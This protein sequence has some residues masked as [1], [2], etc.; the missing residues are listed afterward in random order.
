MKEKTEKIMWSEVADLMDKNGNVVWTKFFV[1]AIW[2]NHEQE[3]MNHLY[4]II[5][6]LYEQYK[7]TLAK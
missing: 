6:L 2:L 3:K 7:K 1:Y 4:G 5:H